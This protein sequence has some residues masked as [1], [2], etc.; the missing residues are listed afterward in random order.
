MMGVHKPYLCVLAVIFQVSSGIETE[1][2]GGERDP[3]FISTFIDLVDSFIPSFRPKAPQAQS[4]VEL[5]RVPDVQKIVK[6]SVER[7]SPDGLYDLPSKDEAI[8]SWRSNMPAQSLSLHNRQYEDY[9]EIPIKVNKFE[10]FKPKEENKGFMKKSARR[11]DSEAIDTEINEQRNIYK[12][13]E[14]SVISSAIAEPYARSTFEDTKVDIKPSN[15]QKTIQSL[16]KNIYQKNLREKIKTLYKNKTTNKERKTAK[17]T[18]PTPPLSESKMRDEIVPTEGFAKSSWSNKRQNSNYVSSRISNRKRKINKV[19]DFQPTVSGFIPSK[20]Q[21]LSSSENEKYKVQS[22]IEKRTLDTTKKI[23]YR[24][25]NDIDNEIDDADL[26]SKRT[27]EIKKIPTPRSFPRNIPTVTSTSMPKVFNAYEDI[28]ETSVDQKAVETF[29]TKKLQIPITKGPET[30][31][32]PMDKKISKGYEQMNFWRKKF[33][34][35]R[36]KDFIF[37]QANSDKTELKKHE[38]KGSQNMKSQTSSEVMKPE[39][40]I[41]KKNNKLEAK[42]IIDKELHKL[43]ENWKDDDWTQLNK[44]KSPFEENLNIYSIS[45]EVKKKP[46]PE[47]RPLK[48]Y[49]GLKTRRVTTTK[50]PANEFPTIDINLTD[51]E[52]TTSASDEEIEESLKKPGTDA[53]LTKSTF[54]PLP[55]P[56]KP[57][58]SKVVHRSKIRWINSSRNKSESFDSNPKIIDLPESREAPVID[59]R[60]DIEKVK[61]RKPTEIKRRKPNI[62]KEMKTSQRPKVEIDEEDEMMKNIQISFNAPSEEEDLTYIPIYLT[63]PGPSCPKYCIR[64][65]VE[66]TRTGRQISR[67]RCRSSQLCSPRQ[68]KNKRLK[69]VTK[70]GR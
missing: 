22:V 32:N 4:F 46:P 49:F 47:K 60:F 9:P 26:Q 53:E 29:H 17:R 52:V 41:E 65:Q 28:D 24:K 2:S 64:V 10:F 35:D 16:K 34:S 61:E 1:E 20:I 37:T 12:D 6:N 5:K 25:R 38:S 21:K 44:R 51:S 62:E 56:H 27:L 63:V 70:E 23:E 18:T 48:P 30:M 67:P 36:I 3:R 43:Q 7:E 57:S 39:V 14:D 59:R 54:V 40:T 55:T 66:V 8:D 68:G 31:E 11:E 19:T 50:P 42:D 13:N 69:T 58:T 15:K 33:K 45:K